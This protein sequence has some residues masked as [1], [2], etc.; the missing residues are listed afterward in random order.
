MSLASN[1]TNDKEAIECLRDHDR[2]YTFTKV[3]K[4]ESEREKQLKIEQDLVM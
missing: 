2:L 4:A 3:Y 1:T